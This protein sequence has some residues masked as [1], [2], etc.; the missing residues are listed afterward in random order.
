M[1]MNRKWLDRVEMNRCGGESGVAWWS[2]KSGVAG[3]GEESWVAGSGGDE[4]GAIVMG[5]KMNQKLWWV[6]LGGDMPAPSAW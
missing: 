5:V 2:G 1:E 3:C 6:M 4:S